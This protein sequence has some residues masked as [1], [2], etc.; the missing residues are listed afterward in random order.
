MEL[1][2]LPL[3]TVALSMLIVG[4]AV[5]LDKKPIENVEKLMVTTDDN[6]DAKLT[7]VSQYNMHE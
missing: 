2:V 5:T 3:V 6:E 4:E 1:C 7:V